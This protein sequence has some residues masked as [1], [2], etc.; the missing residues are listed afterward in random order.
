MR[1]FFKDPDGRRLAI[2]TKIEEYSTNARIIGDGHRL[3]TVSAAEYEN[4]LAEIDFN[5]WSY[6][7]VWLAD[8]D[9][10]QH[11]KANLP[12]SESQYETGNGEGVFVL[13]TPEVKAAHDSDEAGT[14]YTGILDNDSY[15]Y[16]GLKHGAEIPIEM[17]GECRP[18]VPFYWLIENYEPTNK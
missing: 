2:E 13:V 14:T 15:Y 10:L 1:L 4:I 3:I 11:I 7:D 5:G 18:V 16:I 8:P 17:R 9:D 6:S 12:T